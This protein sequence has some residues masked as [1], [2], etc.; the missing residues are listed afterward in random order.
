MRRMKAAARREA[1]MSRRNL[2]IKRDVLIDMIEEDLRHYGW[3]RAANLWKHDAVPEQFCLSGLRDVNYCGKVMHLIRMSV[4]WQACHEL[5]QSLRHELRGE[6]IPP[7][8]WDRLEL[9]RQWSRSDYGCFAFTLGAVKSPATWMLQNE[10]A[11]APKCKLCGLEAPPWNHYWEH[12]GNG[13]VPSD[14]LL[15]RFIWPRA[16]ADIPLCN[17]FKALLREAK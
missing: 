17:Q 6:A 8:D 9:T 14:I 7:F 11:E 4:R 13:D 5:R 10:G 15:R 12:C 16:Q 1:F 2:P 3:Y